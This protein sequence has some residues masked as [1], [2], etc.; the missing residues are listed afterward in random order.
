[1]DK[2]LGA[3][4]VRSN[5]TNLADLMEMDYSTLSYWHKW[6]KANKKKDLF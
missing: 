4:A 2:M 1:M 3:L 6:H 5:F